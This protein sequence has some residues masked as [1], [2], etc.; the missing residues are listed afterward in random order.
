MDMLVPIPSYL[1][2]LGFLAVFYRHDDDDNDTHSVES[3]SW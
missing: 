2:M 1:T 3:V